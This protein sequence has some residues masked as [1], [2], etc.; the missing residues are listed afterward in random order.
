MENFTPLTERIK[1]P[2][3][4]EI[5]F[6]DFALNKSRY[7]LFKA[8]ANHE[9][10]NSLYP[11]E[12]KEKKSES[13]KES[14]YNL[15]VFKQ[16]SEHTKNGYFLKKRKSLNPINQKFN[17]CKL[18][19]SRLNK[20]AFNT[21]NKTEYIDNSMKWKS[22]SNRN[23]SNI[24]FNKA[25]KKYNKI[26]DGFL[27][28][29]FVDRK[30]ENA[31]N[32]NTSLKMN[33]KK[34]DLLNVGKYK[35]H[36]CTLKEKII[37]EVKPVNKYNQKGHC[38]FRENTDENYTSLPSNKS[39]KHFYHDQS[40]DINDRNPFS[41]FVTY[42]RNNTDQNQNKSYNN[43]TKNCHYKD[44]LKKVS[45]NLLVNDLPAKIPVT[46]MKTFFGED[47]SDLIRGETMKFM[48]KAIP[49]KIIK[50][51]A[52]QQIFKLGNKKYSA[53]KNSIKM[54]KFNI[55]NQY[56][57]DIL[58]KENE[59]N[60]KKAEN[61]MKLFKDNVDKIMSERQKEIMDISEDKL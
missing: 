31:N 28:R 52:S 9:Y 33:G 27:N 55:T 50:A 19:T 40:L 47:G 30:D 6:F 25:N 24:S 29:E 2:I 7:E 38:S 20:Q 61:K 32:K 14:K 11:K 4:K 60:I 21:R 5:D 8:R 17:E 34:I 10:Y 1:I 13:L 15:E 12:K 16:N 26:L 18:F 46:K 53:K 45:L 35:F 48:K 22:K 23:L 43:K 49:V 59:K 44:K 3:N 54:K 42:P 37:Y 51:M 56:Y 36:N 58:Y 57:L 39:I 41:N